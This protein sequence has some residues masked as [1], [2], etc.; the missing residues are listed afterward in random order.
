MRWWFS[1]TQSDTVTA[2]VVKLSTDDEVGCTALM[3]TGNFPLHKYRAVTAKYACSF[4]R[5]T[6]ILCVPHAIEWCAAHGVALL[7]EFQNES[8]VFV[9]VERVYECR[10]D[11]RLMRVA[12]AFLGV[13]SRQL[14]EVV[15]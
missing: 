14:E 6:Q 7:E 9:E 4:G 5:E 10:I 3:V 2:A 15:V 1:K 13:T 11:G 8:R 12:P